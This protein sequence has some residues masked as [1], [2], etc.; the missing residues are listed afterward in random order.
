MNPLL[1]WGTSGFFLIVTWILL[2]IGFPMSIGHDRTVIMGI[3][4]VTSVIALIIQ[5]APEKQKP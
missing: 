3:A 4:V 5:C 1:K 2:V